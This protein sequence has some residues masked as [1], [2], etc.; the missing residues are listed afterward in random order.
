LKRRVVESMSFCVALRKLSVRLLCVANDK[1][2]FF[3]K[4][5]ENPVVR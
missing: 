4:V 3:D 2:E 5:F 1:F